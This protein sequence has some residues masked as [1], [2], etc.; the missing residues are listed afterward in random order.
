MR[1]I[2]G[3]VREKYCTLLEAVL[4]TNLNAAVESVRKLSDWFALVHISVFC[5]FV[6]QFLLQDCFASAIPAEDG[7]ARSHCLRACR[8]CFIQFHG[9][10]LFQRG[11]FSIS[12]LSA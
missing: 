1:Y 9:A 12:M 8:L 11:D 3:Q 2:L 4:G 7:Q 5:T 10:V 6:F